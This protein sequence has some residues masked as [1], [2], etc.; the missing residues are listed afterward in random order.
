VT[1]FT[2]KEMGGP[3]MNLEAGD[4]VGIEPTGDIGSGQ[5]QDKQKTMLAELI[6]GVN[7][8]FECELTSNG[9]RVYVNDAIKGKLLESAVLIEQAKSKTKE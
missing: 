1:A 9:K 3:T 8:L 6:A 2:T 5:V 7:D 4:A